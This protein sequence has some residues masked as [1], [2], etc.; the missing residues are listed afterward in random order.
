MEINTTL[1][2]P[3]MFLYALHV[4]ANALLAPFFMLS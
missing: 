3:V 4:G 2:M 1:L